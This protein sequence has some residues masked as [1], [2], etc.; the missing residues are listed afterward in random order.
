ME[1]KA[2]VQKSI[3]KWPDGTSFT[4][5]L[6]EVAPLLGVH[7][8]T[9]HNWVQTGRIECIRVGKSIHFTYDQ[10]VDFINGNRTRRELNSVE[11]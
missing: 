10:V 7:Y 3:Q 1:V 11:V 5:P 2:K 9:L 8:N 4:K 6:R